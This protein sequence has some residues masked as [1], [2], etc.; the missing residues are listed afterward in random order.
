MLLLND[1]SKLDSSDRYLNL[2]FESPKSKC[3]VVWHLQWKF[4]LKHFY[5][6]S[7]SLTVMKGNF[8]L[9]H[10]RHSHHHVSFP[11]SCIPLH[12]NLR[13]FLCIGGKQVLQR[14]HFLIILFFLLQTLQVAVFILLLISVISLFIS[15]L[16][17]PLLIKILCSCV[18]LH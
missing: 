13:H 8:S 14:T 10:V 16:G 6:T 1:L 3:E 15:F 2:N 7:L 5:I 18:S 12:C 11:I 4:E 17:F 9:V